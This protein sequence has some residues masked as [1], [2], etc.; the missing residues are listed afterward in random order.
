M[1][2]KKSAEILE[3]YRWQGLYY[4][5]ISELDKEK[6]NRIVALEIRIPLSSSCHGQIEHGVAERIAQNY[7]I[8]FED[9]DINHGK[10]DAPHYTPTFSDI[11]KG[12]DEIEPKIKR[13]MEARDELYCKFEELTDSAMKESRLISL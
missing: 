8:T 11:C 4:S 12:E 6:G 7:R 3:Q 2:F 13:I 10:E 1:D 5:Y 9:Y